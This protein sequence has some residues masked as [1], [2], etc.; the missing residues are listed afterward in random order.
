VKQLLRKLETWQ[1]N[2]PAKPE[3]NVFSAERD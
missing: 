2:L 1:K 3:G